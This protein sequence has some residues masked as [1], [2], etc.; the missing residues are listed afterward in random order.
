MSKHRTRTSQETGFLVEITN[1][2]LK[3]N[4]IR[5]CQSAAI[6]S[7][8]TSLVMSASISEESNAFLRA[9]KEKRASL[10][11]SL[12]AGGEAVY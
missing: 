9:Q 7:G 4:R 1:Q 12:A 6:G 10:A 5:L 3:F 8:A 2:F 11:M